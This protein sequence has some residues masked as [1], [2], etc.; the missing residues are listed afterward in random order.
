MFNGLFLVFFEGYIEI[1]LSSYLNLCKYMDYTAS[2]IFSLAFAI[3]CTLVCIVILPIII[4]KIIF[5][6]KEELANTNFEAK[7]GSAY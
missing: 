4:I 7:Y 5:K 6:D 1:L 2:D 3:A